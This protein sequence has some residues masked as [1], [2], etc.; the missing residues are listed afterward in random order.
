MKEG[1][2]GI[3]KDRME[4]HEGEKERGGGRGERGGL[5][6]RKKKR[7]EDRKEWKRGRK[8]RTR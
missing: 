8:E 2:K 3:I 6:R 5:E 4:W 1:R 7:E